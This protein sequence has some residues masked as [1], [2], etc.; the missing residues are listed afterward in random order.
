MMYL[1]KDI[2]YE[3]SGHEIENIYHLGQASTMLGLLKYPG[4][5]SESKGLN[6][7]W[8]KDTLAEATV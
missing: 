7:S 3:L 5:F 1:F 4:D 6:Q 8:Y 2:R